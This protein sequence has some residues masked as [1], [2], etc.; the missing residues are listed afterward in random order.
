MNYIPIHP[1]VLLQASCLDMVGSGDANRVTKIQL[2]M[3]RTFL[4]MKVS[5]KEAEPRKRRRC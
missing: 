1:V 5:Q 2:P 3:E 4:S